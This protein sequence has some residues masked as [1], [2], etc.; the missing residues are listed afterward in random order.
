MLK[1]HLNYARSVT[2]V[3]YLKHIRWNTGPK[4][5]ESYFSRFGT[6]RKVILNYDPKCGLHKGYGNV[7][8]SNSEGVLNAIEHK[9]HMIDGDVVDVEMQTR[10]QR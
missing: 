9:P 2:N 6:V 3:L 7:V 4:Q 8:F 5:I 1:R 10:T